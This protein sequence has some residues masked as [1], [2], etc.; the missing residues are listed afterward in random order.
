VSARQLYCSDIDAEI[1]AEWEFDGVCFVVKI[2]EQ[3]V[4]VG[5]WA[6][7]RLMTQEEERG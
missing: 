4:C 7:D 1:D 3:T 2:P 5:K 6:R